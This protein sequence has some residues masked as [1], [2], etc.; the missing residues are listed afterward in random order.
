[1]SSLVRPT[2]APY[3]RLGSA[4]GWEPLLGADRLETAGGTVRLGTPGVR[5]I[6]DG[7]PYGSMGGRTLVRGLVIGPDGEVLL[8]DPAARVIRIRRQPV[9]GITPDSADPLPALWPARPTGDAM[10]DPYTLLRPVDLAFTPNGDL[11]IADAGAGRLLVLAYPRAALRRVI[12]LPGWTPVAVAVDGNGHCYVADS[13]GL[14]GAGATVHR[15][16]SRW[17]RAAVYP[18]PGTALDAPWQLAVATAGTCPAHDAGFSC[19][20]AGQPREG[21]AA[22]SAPVLVVADGA[23]LVLLDNRGRRLPA[24]TPV[25]DLAEPALQRSPEGTL[26][27][28][29][30]KRPNHHPL[31]FPGLEIDRT[32]SQPDTGLA[33]VALPTRLRLP[34]AGVLRLGPLVGDG[35]GFVWDRLVLD[36]QIPSGTALLIRTLASDGLP[37]A[38]WPDETQGAWSGAAKLE[39]QTPPELLVQGP[40]GRYLWI[41]LELRGTGH[42]TPVLRRLDVHA[43]RRSSLHRLPPG[44]RQ[45][46]DSAGFLDRFLSYFDTIFAEAQ[47]EHRD[48]AL[49]LDERTAPAGTALDWLGSWFGLDFL[50][51]WPVS[52]RRR[53]I[54]EAMQYSVERGS[55]P[56]IQRLLS[57][58]TGLPSPW[59]VVIEHFRLSELSP[60]VGRSPLPAPGAAHRC[61]IVLP[62]SAVPG[63]EQQRE[64]S[65]L[66]AAQL[67]AHVRAEV[68]YIRPG[69]VIGAQSSIAVDT[70]LG[71]AP[72]GALGAAQLGIETGFGTDA[73]PTQYPRSSTPC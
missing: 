39:S 43:P 20:C 45:D 50:P 42:A 25:P 55:I 67:P 35:P 64:L 7:E 17:R 2:T 58:H 26:S 60:P 65:G 38:G 11:V 4:A 33:L 40:A 61:T 48:A 63:P 51:G 41:E 19:D 54:S 59:P 14:R 24:G 10:H 37:E 68:R 18:H 21:R 32:G 13:T 47:A 31:L 6:A 23:T 8:A 16:D 36:A 57:W 5:H 53:A 72:H 1:M 44:F 22:G 15:F 9:P 28:A 66:L 52:T 46:Q 62:E 12:S 73:H 71:G 30:P 27:W 34:Q 56:G 70:L 29:D 3:L 49:L 69:I